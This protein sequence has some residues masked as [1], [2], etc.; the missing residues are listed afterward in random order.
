MCGHRHFNQTTVKHNF[1]DKAN[2]LF[3]LWENCIE[4]YYGSNLAFSRYWDIFWPLFPFPFFLHILL[5]SIYYLSSLL[6]FIC[7]NFNYQF[8]KYLAIIVF[9]IPYRVNTKCR[10]TCW[11]W[12]DCTLHSSVTG[13][14]VRACICSD[15]F[16]QY[17]VID[18]C[19]SVGLWWWGGYRWACLY[20]RNMIILHEFPCRIKNSHPRDRNFKRGRGLPSPWLK[21]RPRGWNFHLPTQGR[22]VLTFKHDPK[23]IL[24]RRVFL[25]GLKT[26]VNPDCTLTVAWKNDLLNITSYRGQNEMQPSL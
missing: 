13:S 8:W 17:I 14:L 2:R 21:V 24:S 3:N 6:P 22:K 5:F 23:I 10:M 20:T 7:L 25:S 9:P 19:L 18:F 1:D 11:L 12:P 16:C 4:S 15:T 26:G